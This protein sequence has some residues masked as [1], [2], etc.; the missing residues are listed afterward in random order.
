MMKVTF[1]FDLEDEDQ[2]ITFETFLAS[3]N[4]LRALKE[5]RERIRKAEEY[6]NPHL[7]L[8]NFYELLD[9]RTQELL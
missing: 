8:D 1:E 2:N 3:R 4:M 5:I 7:T 6:G 9:S